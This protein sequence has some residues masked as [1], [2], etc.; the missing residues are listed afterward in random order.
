[1]NNRRHAAYIGFA[2]ILPPL[3]LW[4]SII[5]YFVANVNFLYRLYLAV[6]AVEMFFSEFFIVLGY[7][8]AAIAFGI[9]ARKK[10]AEIDP[11]ARSAGTIIITLGAIFIFL[12][13]LA[14]LQPR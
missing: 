7:P 5:V 2:F 14:G 6:P 12:T 13:L 3:V 8:F 1:M 11:F 4:L 9:M 10:T